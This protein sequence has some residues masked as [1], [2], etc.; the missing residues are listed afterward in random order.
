LRKLRVLIDFQQALADLTASPELCNAA[1]ADATVLQARYVLTE[2]E[3][4]RLLSIVRHPGMAGACT[5][6]R[7]NRLAP[8]AL[9]LRATLHSLGPEARSLLSEYWRD[10]PHGHA[11]FLLESDRFC[12]WLRLRIDSGEITSPAASAAL[13]R[14]TVLVREAL[15]ASYTEMSPI[16]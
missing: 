7:M 15:E 1:R 6:Y 10:H 14:E 16:Q 9:N 8:L 5:V 12:R 11:H 13:Q 3:L 2:R 4:R